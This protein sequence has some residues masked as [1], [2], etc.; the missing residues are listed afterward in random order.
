MLDLLSGLYPWIKTLHL[1]AVISWMA[2]LFYL[3][4]LLVHHVERSTP[5]SGSELDTTFQMME[6]KLHRVIM[7]PAMMVAWV[8]GLIM[9]A[10]GYLDFGAIWGWV[11][12]LGVIAMT[13]FHIWLGKE[14]KAVA[15]GQGRTGRAY[16]LANEVPT[17]LMLLILVAVIVRPF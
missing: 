12:F 7:N 5:G 1:A 15:Q 14:R 17:V 3:P 10:L 13:G 2:A 4:R 8:C 9:I 11:K 6:E 16:R